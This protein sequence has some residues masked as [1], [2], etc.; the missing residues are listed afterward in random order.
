MQEHGLYHR[1]MVRRASHRGISIYSNDVHMLV[2]LTQLRTGHINSV[3]FRG[4][5]LYLGRHLGNLLIRN[6]SD[7]SVCEHWNTVTAIQPPTN[8]YYM[9][10]SLNTILHS[11]SPVLLHYNNLW[12]GY[13]FLLF[14]F[15]LDVGNHRGRMSHQVKEMG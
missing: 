3:S 4:Q 11:I 7:N 5:V 9:K 8:M 15:D 1:Q 6:T 10:F 13:H 2:L 14:F 12:T